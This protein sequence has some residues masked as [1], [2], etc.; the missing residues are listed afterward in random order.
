MADL[1]GRSFELA[2]GVEG[3]EG[4]LIKD[5]RV[6]FKV[7]KDLE[8]K[9]N[10]VAID[11]YN[12]NSASKAFIEQKNTTVILNA[13]Y[14]ENP[15]TIFIG[16]IAKSVTRIQ[17]ADMITTIDAGDGEKAYAS[18][19]INMSKG[20][21]A[22][23]GD[24]LNSLLNTF[25][26]AKGSVSDVNED[27]QFQQGITM[28]GMAKDQLDT[29]AARQ[30]LEWSI[31]DGLVQISKPENPTMEEAVLITPATGLIGSPQKTKVVNQSLLKKK[32]GKEQE[33]GVKFVCLLNGD[34]KPGRRIV[35]ESRLVN[36]IFKVQKVTHSGDS[37]SKAWY[38]EVEAV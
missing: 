11:I 3:Q 14:G 33:S 1:F 2:I 8:S 13:G 5:L 36:G 16:D 29:L 27:D 28:S 30:G 25:G 17:G 21:G 22:K 9:P 34:I 35:L 31:Q 12:L 20:P 19:Y 38:T 18:K 32:D 23:F 24:V 6:V 4:I 37:R 7:E 10:N 26:L 15:K